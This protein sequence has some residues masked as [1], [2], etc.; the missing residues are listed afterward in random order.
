MFNN[1]IPMPTASRA[2]FHI[3]GRED[4]QLIDLTEPKSIEVI[5]KLLIE[6][7]PLAG[8]NITEIF[9]Y[10]EDAD[11]EI[12]HDCVLK[13]EHHSKRFHVHHCRE[14][15]VTF[16]YVDDRREQA[17]RPSA[18]VAKLL[19]WAKDNF[20]VDRSGK[21]VLRLT[22][23][24]DPLPHAAHVGSYTKPNDCALTLYFAP[25]CRIQG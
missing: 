14:I 1:T 2:H 18:T 13:A 20:P 8:A 15:K 4:P 5:I 23:D 24:G 3:E 12:P 11:D 10:E 25:A 7:G 22:A 17:F 9:V 16:I 19:Q 21:Y 6:S